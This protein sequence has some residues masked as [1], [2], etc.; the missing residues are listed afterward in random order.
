[1]S[2]FNEFWGPVLTRAAFTSEKSVYTDLGQ[3]VHNFRL[4]K[5]DLQAK[6]AQVQKRQELYAKLNDDLQNK[7]KDLTDQSNAKT[8]LLTDT[9][10]SELRYRTLLASMRAQYQSIEN[11]MQAYEDQ[12]RK[13]LEEQ[14]KIPT[15]SSI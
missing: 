13:K 11:E 7:Y 2:A 1:M 10:A 8:K 4:A 15:D 14:D 5:E 12:V 3:S 9:H 6:Q